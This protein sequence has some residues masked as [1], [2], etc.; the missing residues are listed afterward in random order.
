MGRVS[1]PVIAQGN[2][3]VADSFRDEP[4]ETVQNVACGTVRLT[5]SW[6]MACESADMKTA[7]VCRLSIRVCSPPDRT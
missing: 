6:L 1:S 2:G 4:E 3:L 5:C 7:T